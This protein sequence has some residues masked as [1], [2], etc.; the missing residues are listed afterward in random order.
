MTKKVV[1]EVPETSVHYYNIVQKG[2]KLLIEQWDYT[3]VALVKK[4][5]T[6]GITISTASLNLIIHNKSAGFRTLKRAAEGIST[7]LSSEFALS[8]DRDVERFVENKPESWKA[9]PIPESPS[10]APP[11]TIH[12][13]GRVSV[14]EK[15]DFIATA[16]QEVI[17]VGIRLNSFSNYFV[18]QNE[19]AY[20]AHIVNLLERGV[21][22]R[23]YLLNPESNEARLY[24]EDRASIQSSEK[25]S[26]DD[27]KRI[28]E[29]L[30]Q[31]SAE[32]NGLQFPGKF[33][34]FLYK[35]I[36]CNFF[37]VVDGGLSSGKMM[38]SPYLYGIRRAN[39]PVLEFS[40]KD[41]PAMFRKYWE[42]LQYF[43]ERADR[44]I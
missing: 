26:I 11:I 4:M 15:T 44:L 7:I 37:F 2:A 34:I 3:Q 33:E 29:R 13:D 32:L 8:Y 30:R 21:N 5:K 28:T 16:T 27:I 20:K 22:V 9:Q 31:V 35:H 39:C 38:V 25:D 6:L 43:T 23:G 1:K 19:K 42:S 18:S 14:K 17:E 36:P 12:P 10:D 40:K 24:F 41:Q